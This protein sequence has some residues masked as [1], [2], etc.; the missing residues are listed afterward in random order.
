M[1]LGLFF[2]I[3]ALVTNKA[4]EFADDLVLRKALFGHDKMTKKIAM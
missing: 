2:V 4:V 3:E 1:S